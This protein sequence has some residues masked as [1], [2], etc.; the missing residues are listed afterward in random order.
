MKTERKLPRRL[1]ARVRPDDLYKLFSRHKVK[2]KFDVLE[3]S[4]GGSPMVLIEGDKISLE[5]LAKLILA[6]SEDKLNCG[7][8]RFQ[9]QN[10]IADDS[11]MG[12]Y[13]H[14]L[15]CTNP[16]KL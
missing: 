14:C 5:Y 3:A 12:V 16:P 11:P 7:V 10:V 9:G 15:P 1:T 4:E 2:L 13:I 6:Q 8:Q